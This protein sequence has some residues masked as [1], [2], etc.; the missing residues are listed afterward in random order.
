MAREAIV[1]AWIKEKKNG[2]LE[3]TLITDQFVREDL[4]VEEGKA[5]QGI[6]S[7]TV[8]IADSQELFGQHLKELTI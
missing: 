1:K 6:F 5:P 3:I 7:T 4:L 8:V 2:L